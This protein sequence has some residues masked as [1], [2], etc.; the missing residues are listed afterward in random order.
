MAI[1]FRAARPSDI[2]ALLPMVRQF[3]AT[4]GLPWDEL[5]VRAALVGLMVRP[6]AGAVWVLDADGS[7]AGY[8]VVTLCYSLEYNGRDAFV[9]ELYVADAFRRRGFG[10]RALQVAETYCQMHEAHTLHLVVRPGNKAARALYQR[11]GFTATDRLLLSRAVS[12]PQV[13][14]IGGPCDEPA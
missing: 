4:E 2:E 1:A 11:Y 6:H 14:C 3:R 9:D 10:R 8:L 7:V 13:M 5:N 12:L